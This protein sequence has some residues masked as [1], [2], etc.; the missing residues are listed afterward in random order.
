MRHEFG[1]RAHAERRMHHERIGRAAEERDMGEVAHRIEAGVFVHGRAEHVG[2]DA[3]H[4]QRVAVGRGARDVLGR[5]EAAGAGAVLDVK[6]LAECFAQRL[7]IKAAK[8]IGGAARRKRHHDAHRP[9]RP[10]CR[11]DGA[12]K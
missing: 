11:A 10:V 9:P 5:N 3:R 1:E 6:L 12:R 7:G 8:R 2:R 4:H